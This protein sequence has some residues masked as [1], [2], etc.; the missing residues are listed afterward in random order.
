MPKISRFLYGKWLK[1]ESTS[2]LRSSENTFTWEGSYI[3][4][5]KNLHTRSIELKKNS[6]ILEDAVHTAERAKAHF[7]IAPDI[8]GLNFSMTTTGEIK[9]SISEISFFYMQKEEQNLRVI[10]FQDKCT[11][12]FSWKN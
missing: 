4:Y 2:P 5:K 8:Q 1:L 10:N 9:E 7:H 3:D 12:Q 11:T 6:L